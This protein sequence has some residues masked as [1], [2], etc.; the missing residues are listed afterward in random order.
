M[1]SQFASSWHPC[2]LR[3][4]FQQK[5]GYSFVLSEYRGKERRKT[6]LDAMIYVRTRVN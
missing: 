5:L 2:N 3:S 4:G 6:G 1:G